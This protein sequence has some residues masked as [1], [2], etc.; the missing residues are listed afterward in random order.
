M[1]ERE[2]QE[3]QGEVS[4]PLG[5]ILYPIRGRLVFASILSALGAMLT[6]LPL[7]LIAFVIQTL[8]TATTL[9]FGGSDDNQVLWLVVSAVISLLLGMLFMTAGELFAHLADHHLTGDLQRKITQHL[10]KVPLGWF[11]NHSSGTVKQIMQDDV[12][13]L[14]SL[15]AHFYP[16]VGR[17]VGAIV[18][19]VFFL[20]FM[21]WRLALITFLPFAGFVM[22]LRRA[23]QASGDNIQDFAAQ[24]GQVNSA[25]V[26]F[27]HAIAVVK[28]FVQNG[29]ASG[30]YQQ[31]VRDFAQ[32]FKAFTRPLIQAM[33]HAHAMVSPITILGVVMLGGAGLIYF[34]KLVAIDLLPFVLVAPAICAPVLL[35]H[36][37]LHDLQSSEAAAQRIL[38]LLETPIVAVQTTQ[39][40]P[41]LANSEVCFE[42]VS[43]A[44]KTDQ[45]VLS[46]ISFCLT[47]GT[48]TAIVGPSG[49]GKST[50]AQLLLRFFDPTAGKI[51][52][53]GINLTEIASVTL[54]QQIG[55]VLQDTRLIHTSIRENIALG[56]ENATQAEIEQ[57]AQAA[58]IHERIMTL[59]KQY[60]SIVGDDVQLSGGER[61]RISIARAILLDPPILILDEA[62]AAADI[63]NEIAIQQALSRFAQGR[64]LLVI[65]HRLDT[66]MHADRILV[67]DRGQIVEQGTHAQLLQHQGTY[68]QLWSHTQIQTQQQLQPGENA[69]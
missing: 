63:D 36:T 60:D 62:T 16:A 19:A 22:F 42:Q 21:D 4:S 20:L 29:Q 12:G 5:Q 14:H 55:F 38:A 64:T 47:P 56:R 50:I 52:L 18:L 39:Q 25:T 1:C 3:V 11:T 69:C 58:N 46:N 35:L 31:A 26:E 37:L 34:G 33:A 2:A 68:A 10:A 40:Q 65:A 59:P 51:T 23:M 43:Y 41:L 30:G 54:Y 7:I 32:A 48:V 61:Q 13:L 57:A 8:V 24:L 17:A 44:Y 27:A 66:V 49:A 67:L 53:G 15:T 45:L 9:A 6:L 28:T